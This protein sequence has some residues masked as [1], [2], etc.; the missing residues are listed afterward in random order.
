[1]GDGLSKRDLR[2]AL[3]FIAGAYATRDLDHFARYVADEL[4]AL[5][6][7]DSAV[8]NEVNLRRGRVRWIYAGVP[9]LP[10]SEQVFEAHIDD[11]PFIRY[12]AQPNSDATVTIGDF[13]SDREW[14]RRGIYNEFY[15]PMGV[16]RIIGTKIPSPPELTIAFVAVRSGKDYTARDRR[17]FD[18]LRPHLFHAY[19]I[20][21][22]RSDHKQDLDL[23][24]QSIDA[25]RGGAIVLAP[26]GRMR[27]VTAKA[28]AWLTTYFAAPANTIHLPEALARWVTQSE[29]PSAEDCEPPAPSGSF[30]VER[31][32]RRLVAQLLRDRGRRLILLE[33]RPIAIG[34]ED[35]A[36]LGLAQREAEI[37][38]CLAL[39]KTDAE[40]GRILGISPRTVS[41]TLER[42]YRKLGVETRVA[43]AMRAVRAARAHTA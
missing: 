9:P 30:V 27:M 26:D 32:G 34:P 18:L 20:A 25:L 17:M 23:L 1:M 19:E 15:R 3:N 12:Y 40:I 35:L 2:A 31:G 24:H 11:H 33:E 22:A 6:P 38:A 39:G 8:Y 43:A 41:H 7:T 21:A 10:N 4:M 16:E 36:S 14:R 28:R 5:V 37:L 42:I 13:L 29:L